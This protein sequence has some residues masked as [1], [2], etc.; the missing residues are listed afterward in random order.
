MCLFIA[1]PT[2][3]WYIL[4]SQRDEQESR[5]TSQHINFDIHKKSYYT[6]D[7]E[8]WWT[9]FIHHENNVYAVIL[10]HT[11]HLTSSVWLHS[12]W[13][14]PLQ[15]IDIYNRTWNINDVK[16]ELLQKWFHMY[17]SF[18]L[19]IGIF[20][21][22]TKQLNHHI[23]KWNNIQK[24]ITQETCN[25]KLFIAATTL[26]HK[27]I[28]EDVIKRLPYINDLTTLNNY[29]NIHKYNPESEYCI[30]KEWVIVKSRTYIEYIDSKLQCNFT[31]NL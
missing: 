3:N 25:G 30:K 17:N 31:T 7:Q 14:L 4:W 2:T 12:R 27:N 13:K 23:I 10:N 24:T 22:N 9:R 21:K 6:I 26:Y 19:A 29:L 18:I 8:S 16:D 15:C 28:E 20:D 1:I 5:V 11:P